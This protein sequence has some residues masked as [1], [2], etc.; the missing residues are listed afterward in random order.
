MNELSWTVEREARRVVVV[1]VGAVTITTSGEFEGVLLAAAAEADVVLDLAGV[2]FVDSSGLSA[3]VAAYKAGVAHGHTVV[4]D[5][6]PPFLAR[7]LKV[8]G[9]GTLLLSPQKVI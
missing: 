2:T 6:V 5:P 8:T 1:P 9:L 3:F 4:L 7:V